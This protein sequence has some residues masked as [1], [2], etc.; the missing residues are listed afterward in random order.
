[1]EKNV[2]EYI[3][4]FRRIKK[5]LNREKKQRQLRSINRRFTLRNSTRLRRF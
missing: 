3:E 2:E 1:M 5:A 4:R